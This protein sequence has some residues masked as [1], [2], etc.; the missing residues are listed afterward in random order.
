[1]LH[2][3]TLFD[4]NY[5]HYGL[6]LHTSLEQHAP[7]Y[8][9]YV[10]AF[11]E[12]CEDLLQQMALPHVTVIGLQAFEDEDLLR[13]KPTRSKGEY[14]WTCTP[15]TIRYVLDTYGV[16]HCTYIDS[17][18][19]FFSD[20]TPLVDELGEDSVSLIE[21]RYSPQYDQTAKSGKY[22]VQFMT[23]R[24]DTRGREILAWWR[25]ACIEWCYARMEDGKFGDQKYLDDWTTR[26]QGVR[27][28][29]HQGGG[30]APWNMQQYR[31]EEAGDGLYVTR[32]DSPDRFRLVFF[33]FH[34]LKIINRLFLQWCPHNYLLPGEAERLVYTPY[35]AALRTS[36]RQ[37]GKCQFRARYSQ[38]F[39]LKEC[40][41]LWRKRKKN[42]RLR[43][44]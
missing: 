44:V 32:Y 43:W 26:F 7:A 24:N 20:P 39:S 10:F 37:L 28:L 27:E 2:F 19:Y 5:L 31:L 3:C 34:G 23:F 11:D 18:L 41:K 25:N 14:C 38:H 36:I 29:Q 40:L 30:V 21:H 6:A 33:H 8:H 12:T 9:L 17:D 15:S 22:C 1:M 4:S 13:V 16:D 42:V 35:L